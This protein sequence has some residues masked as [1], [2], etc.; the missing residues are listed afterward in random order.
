MEHVV[1]TTYVAGAIGRV[2]EMHARYYSDAWGF[3]VYFEA[4]VAAELAEFMTRFHPGRDFFKVALAQ[5]RVHGSIAIDGVNA[6]EEGAHLRWFIT[7]S[8]LREAGTGNR[9]LQEAVDFC[10]HRGYPRIYLWTF[11]GLELARHLYEKFGFRL[12]EEH[13]GEQWGT[14]VLEQKFVLDL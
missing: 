9:L 3:G 12:A 7:S 2:T 6:A 5:G 14:R 4:K 11:E 10:K 8:V 1:L 13:K